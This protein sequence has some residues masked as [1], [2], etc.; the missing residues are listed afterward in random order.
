MIMM[1]PKNLGRCFVLRE[2]EE[3]TAATFFLGVR[4]SR[5]HR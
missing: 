1:I 3:K 4:T 2:V 5:F